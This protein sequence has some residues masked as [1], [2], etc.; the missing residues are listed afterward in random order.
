MPDRKMVIS[1]L[2]NCT[3]TPKCQDCPWEECDMDCKYFELPEGLAIAAL[4]LLKEQEPVEPKVLTTGNGLAIA[5]N[6]FSCGSC[7]NSIDPTDNFC[8]HCGKAV[9]WDE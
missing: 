5:T 3:R 8:R 7:K 9:K 4:A 2:E 1:A 6:W